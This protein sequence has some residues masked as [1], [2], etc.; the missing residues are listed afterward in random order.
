MTVTDNI[1]EVQLPPATTLQIVTDDTGPFCAN[2]KSDW[3]AVIGFSIFGIQT[4]IWPTSIAASA[5]EP[6]LNIVDP[7]LLAALSIILAAARGYSLYRNGAF[8]LGPW[9]RCIGA[10]I[11][12]LFMASMACALLLQVIQAGRP[13]SPGIPWYLALMWLEYSSATR[14]ARDVRHRKL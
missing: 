12:V 13:P 3:G 5:F 14:A 1:P 8:P 4:A 2:R 6:I 11:G 10:G 7:R 9:I